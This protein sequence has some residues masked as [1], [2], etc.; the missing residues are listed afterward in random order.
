MTVKDLIEKLSKLPQ[1]LE[2]MYCGRE[3]D[4]FSVESVEESIIYKNYYKNHYKTQ[5]EHTDF[6]ESWELGPLQHYAG[7]PNSEPKKVI[8]L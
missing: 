5:P 3:D 2:V 8:M 1:H 6:F 7:V 4:L